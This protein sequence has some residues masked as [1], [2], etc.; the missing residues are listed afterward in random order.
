M[1]FLIVGTLQLERSCQLS[2]G[3]NGRGPGQEMEEGLA[4]KPVAKSIYLL[5][6]PSPQSSVDKGKHTKKKKH[7]PA[8]VLAMPNA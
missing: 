3:S 2:S 4:S 6:A 5:M 1:G 8:L 7:S